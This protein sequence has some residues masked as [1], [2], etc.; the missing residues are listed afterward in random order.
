[1]QTSTSDLVNTFFIQGVDV[2]VAFLLFFIFRVFVFVVIEI[3]FLDIG[4]ADG[5]LRFGEFTR[6][7]ELVGF[8]RSVDIQLH[9]ELTFRLLD[10]LMRAGWVDLYFFFGFFDSDFRILAFGLDF[11]LDFGAF[12]EES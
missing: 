3:E 8:A 9:E 2:N 10:G 4:D 12:H 7:S 1:M 11:D 5:S 6:M